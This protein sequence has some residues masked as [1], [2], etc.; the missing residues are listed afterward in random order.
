MS[1]ANHSQCRRNH[2][3]AAWALGAA[4]LQT[5]ALF[6]LPFPE[7]AMWPTYGLW[8]SVIGA[9]MGTSVW[10]DITARRL[11]QK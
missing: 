2:R 8:A 4:I 5:G 7:G 10:D 6:W 1:E 9:Q 11:G 3:L